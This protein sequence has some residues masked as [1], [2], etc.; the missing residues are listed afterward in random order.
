VGEIDIVEQA[1][2]AGGGR[3]RRASRLL[4]SAL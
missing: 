4:A 3:L 1:R 2:H